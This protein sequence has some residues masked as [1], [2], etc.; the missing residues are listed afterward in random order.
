MPSKR[1]GTPKT[2]SGK[3][4]S[5]KL[6]SQAPTKIDEL[7]EYLGSFTNYEQQKSLPADR[8]ELGPQRAA[9]LLNL[10]GIY[11]LPMPVIQ[12][13][14]SK[15]KGSTVLWMES[16]LRL[17]G[18][19]PGCYLSPHLERINE[20]VRLDG[21]EIPDEI[22][23]QVLGDIHPIL[24]EIEK[25]EPEMMPTFFDLWTCLALYLF[26]KADAS[27]VLLEVGLGGPLDST[28]A[29]PHQVGVLTSVD[30]EHRS[31]LG[32]DLDTIAREKARIARENRPFVIADIGESWGRVA[33][34]QAR[35]QGAEIYAAPIDVRVPG[36]VEAPQDRNLAV[37][38]ATLEAL[39]GFEPFTAQEVASSVQAISLHGRLEELTGPPPLLLDSAH[40]AKSMAYFQRRF[41]AWRG[42]RQGAVLV[43]FVEGKDWDDAVAP[44]E[45][46]GASVDW[47]ITTPNPAR[48]SDPGPLAKR[49]ASFGGEVVI[50]E[51]LDEAV[52]LLRRRYKQGSALAV[53]GSFYL[54][55]HVRSVW[56]ELPIE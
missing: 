19:R 16:L 52:K 17:R 9:H 44:F 32:D 13:A 54:A 36:S 46:D 1:S 42:A 43:G 56:N 4:V 14:G 30:L 35:S 2:P 3:V 51:D 33:A 20:R 12:V 6:P 28:S 31:E 50:E 25:N 22:I 41:I 29:V 37:A 45:S 39:D 34:V 5:A 26:S 47:I 11:P 23:V 8:R 49:L 18:H 15:G 21:D 53:T 55:G 24:V 10:L 7:A 27:H 48:R 40:T 38:L